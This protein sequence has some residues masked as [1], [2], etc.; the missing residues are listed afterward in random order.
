MSIARAAP[1]FSNLTGHALKHKVVEVG[2]YFLGNCV[3][4]PLLENPESELIGFEPNPVSWAELQRFRDPRRT[5]LQYAIG[6]GNR[7]PL[8]FCAAKD[9]TSLLEPNLNVMNLFHGFPVWGRVVSTESVQTVRLDDVAEIAGMTFLQMDIQGAELLALQHAENRLREALVLHLEVEFLQLYVDQPLFSD[10]EQFLRHRG[11][12]F[13]R[14]YDLTS[15]VI[16]PMMVDGNVMSG[17]NQALW[18][19]AVFVRD[20]SRLER[21]DNRELLFL[22]AIV[23]DCYNSWDLT[24]H[25]LL[26]LDRRTGGTL[27]PDYLAALRGGAGRVSE[28]ASVD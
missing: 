23:H 13:H 16:Q 7:R 11:Y 10:I 28:L 1:S 19:D 24:Q 18:A 15:R 8:H 21:L 3:Y 12:L 26:E 2:A 20:F 14:F 4:E 5:F 25:L 17:L 9:M 27:A 22:A 6:D